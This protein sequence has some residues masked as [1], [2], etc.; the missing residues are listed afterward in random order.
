MKR[1]VWARDA[2]QCQW[3]LDTGGICACTRR[4]ELDHVRPKAQGGPTTIENLRVLCRFHN[5]LSA[6]RAFG[7]AWMD[8]FTA[9]AARG[10]SDGAPA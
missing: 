3:P 7:D 8:G 2:G 1:A 4:L 10:R 9:E 6:R 5:T